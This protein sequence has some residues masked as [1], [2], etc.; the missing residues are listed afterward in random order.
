MLSKMINVLY[1]LL[2]MTRFFQPTP[3]LRVLSQF[4]LHST[5][6]RCFVFMRGEILSLKY[7]Y[8]SNSNW[9]S[10]LPEVV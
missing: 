2:F 5:L 10:V 8:V 4:D 9:N 7:E 1:C 3:L 6:L